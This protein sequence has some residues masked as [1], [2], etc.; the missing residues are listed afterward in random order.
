MRTT[1]SF[2]VFLASLALV[3]GVLSVP[4]NDV[5]A[6]VM[7]HDYHS[8]FAAV[9]FDKREPIRRPNRPTS[10]PNNAPTPAPSSAAAAPSSKATQ[11]A[12]SSQAAA[13]SSSSQA[14]ASSSSAQATSSQAA[15]SSSSAGASSAASSSSQAA[16]PTVPASNFNNPS[17]WEMV[18]DLISNPL[19]TNCLEGQVNNICGTGEDPVPTAEVV[20]EPT[21]VPVRRK[22]DD[23]PSGGPTDPRYWSQAE[24]FSGKLPDLG[25]DPYLLDLGKRE[26][27]FRVPGGSTSKPSTNTNTKPNTNTNT[28]TKTNDREFPGLDMI[29]DMVLPFVPTMLDDQQTT[30]DTSAPAV[31]E[32][33]TMSR[34]ELAAAAAE[35]REPIFGAI[36]PWLTTLLG[37]AASSVSGGGEEE[38]Q[39]GQMA[40]AKREIASMLAAREPRINI[41]DVIG[42]FVD[43]IGPLLGGQM[44]RSLVDEA[45]GGAEKDKAVTS[46]TTIPT[47]AS[48]PTG[49]PE[50]AGKKPGDA[51]AAEPSDDEVIQIIEENLSEL[52]EKL[53]ALG[54]G[55]D[56][57]TA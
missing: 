8:P 17:P 43:V 4:V 19:L 48:K 27:K 3:P 55:K 12:S 11:A 29:P 53:S 1:T 26:P 50:A 21:G 51:N 5:H 49:K 44:K 40:A 22:V 16:Q 15:P 37:S 2:G 25:N 34:R 20:V 33:A 6:A 13:P 10:R 38:E 31:E 46:T 23:L 32:G 57:K 9:A 45:A 18:P 35:K 14:A 39:A 28:D 41:G 52:V 42:P 36:A 7:P 56:K 47:G 54:G 30:E 24:S